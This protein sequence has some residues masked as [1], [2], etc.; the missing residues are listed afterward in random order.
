MTIELV[1]PR[2]SQAAL[3]LL[4]GV[5][6]ALAMESPLHAAYMCI[7]AGDGPG[8][9]SALSYAAIDGQ[10]DQIRLQAG[11]YYLPSNFTL[12]YYP[13]TEQ[14]SLEI[15]GGYS[16]Y[17]NDPCGIR[18][19]P[20]DAR[21]TVLHGGILS[22]FLPEGTGSISVEALTFRD[23]FSNNQS[24]IPI[25]ISGAGSSTG[26]IT[27]KNSMF[28]GNGSFLSAA[29]FFGATD[30]ELSIENSVFASNVSTAGVSPIQLGT[31]KQFKGPCLGILGSTFTNNTGTAP[32]VRIDAS[33]CLVLA[34]NSIFWGSGGTT[35]A[36]DLVTPGTAVFEND[37]V[38][39]VAEI[40][41][42]LQIEGVISINPEFNS[43]FSLG[44][45]SPL[46]EAGVNYSGVD[47]DFDA[48]GNSRF[49]GE[50][51]DIGALEIQDVIFAA[52]FQKFR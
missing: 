28:I 35:P 14:H 52:S 24:H 1:R 32:S 46:R 51:V 42:A 17:Q 49:Y 6:I 13:N 26:S 47:M 48:F 27:I 4:S 36:I 16:D 29:V 34:T 18:L 12:F 45:F 15:S 30:G 39:D 10:D 3:R 40:Q 38:F 43:D 7:E 33:T 2:R 41:G 21:Q 5:A 31:S 11:D 20:P 23:A 9:Q 37:N 50:H 25:A 22:L 44:D 8:L 19:T